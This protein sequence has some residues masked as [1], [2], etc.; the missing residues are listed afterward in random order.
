MAGFRV[1]NAAKG[2]IRKI[3][4]YTQ[5]QWGAVQ[6][7]RYLSGLNEKFTALAQTPEIAAERREFDPPVRIHQYEKHLIVYVIDDEGIL[8]VRVL[9]QSMDVPG[10]LRDT[11][12]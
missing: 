11:R 5:D 10:Q 12:N 2:D 4:R 9:H 3:G 8:I 7:R 6:R 1:S